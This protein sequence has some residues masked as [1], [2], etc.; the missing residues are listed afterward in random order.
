VHELFRREDC[1]SSTEMLVR[2]TK[3]LAERIDGVDL[4]ANEPGDMLDLPASEGRLLL[5]E[6]W[7]IIERRRQHSLACR[8]SASYRSSTAAD[9]RRTA[10]LSG[11]H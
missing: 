2:L 10:E 8:S 6:G 4:S 1:F 9:R 11:R 5:A 3:K 7:A